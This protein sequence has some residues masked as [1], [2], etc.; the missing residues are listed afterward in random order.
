MTRELVIVESPFSTRNGRTLDENLTYLRHC[1]RD[2][3]GRG[4][5]PFASHGFFPLFLREHDSLERK[6]GIEAGFQFWDLVPAAEG[7]VHRPKIVFY[8]DWGISSG[9]KEAMDHVMGLGRKYEI[10]Y[11]GGAVN[12]DI[13]KS[14]E[15]G[16][17]DRAVLRS[18]RPLQP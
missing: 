12:V 5:L 15:A 10:R 14:A 13:G 18:L 2:S 8:C 17:E 11:I 6:E 4:E 3:W 7:E 1:L 16:E 9:M